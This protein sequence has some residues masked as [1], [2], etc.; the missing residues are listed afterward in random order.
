MIALRLNQQCAKKVM[1][2]GPRLVDFAIGLLIFVPNLLDGQM[3]FFQE[4]QI[5]EGL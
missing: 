3:L 4:I 5:T 2:N 1:S